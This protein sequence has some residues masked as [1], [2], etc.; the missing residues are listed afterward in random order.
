MGSIHEFRANTP[1]QT[2]QGGYFGSEVVEAVRKKE[3]ERRAA[4]HPT[5]TQPFN[6]LA[7]QPVDYRVL[8]DALAR[9]RRVRR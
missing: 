2:T 4:K 1:P 9:S 3:A 6:P 5:P 7:P 8:E